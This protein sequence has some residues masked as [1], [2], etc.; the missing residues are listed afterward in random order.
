[1]L[2]HTQFSEPGG[3]SVDCSGGAISGQS[4][5]GDASTLCYTSR[6]DATVNSGFSS[7]ITVK[8]SH[9]SKTGP[10]AINE[11]S[12]SLLSGNS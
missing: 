12:V 9:N 7:R 2:R 4:V 10:I 11:S 8:C 3:T 5:S 1:M 6:L